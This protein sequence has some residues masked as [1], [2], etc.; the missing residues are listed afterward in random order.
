M[1]KPNMNQEAEMI[2]VSIE[3]AKAKVAMADAVRRLCKNKDFKKVFLD[4]FLGTE[5]AR[6]VKLMASPSAQNPA[7]QEALQKMLIAVGQVDQF[8]RMT[9]TLGDMAA[10]GIVD[11]EAELQAILAEEGVE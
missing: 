11:D 3:E 2:E 7:Y 9:L 1:D 4:H 5:V 10:Q 8:M 6:T